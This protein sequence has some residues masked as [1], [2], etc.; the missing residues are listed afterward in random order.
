MTT[1]AIRALAALAGIS[2]LAGNCGALDGNHSPRINTV[3]GNLLTNGGFEESAEGQGTAARGWES[4][5]G[6]RFVVRNAEAIDA[7]VPARD[8]AAAEGCLVSEEAPHSGKRCALIQRTGAESDYFA[9]RQKDIP[10]EP[11]A[12][13]RLRFWVKADA[14]ARELLGV[15]FSASGPEGPAWPIKPVLMGEEMKW[16]RVEVLFRAQVGFNPLAKTDLEFR[17]EQWRPGRLQDKTPERCWLDDVSLERVDGTERAAAPVIRWLVVPNRPGLRFAD[18]E[19]ALGD[20]VEAEDASVEFCRDGV[21][22]RRVAFH[23]QLQSDQEFAFSGRTRRV[24]VCESAARGRCELR[25]R[26]RINPEGG[27]YL[28]LTEPGA[29]RALRAGAAGVERIALA[30]REPGAVRRSNWPVTQGLPFPRGSLAEVSE[31]RVLDPAGREIP[32]QARATSFWEDDSIR[33]ALLD[34]NVEVQP[35]QPTT[36]QVEYGPGARRAQVER[37]IR[38][39]EDGDLIRVDTGPLQFTVSKTHFRAFENVVADGRRALSGS[40]TIQVT[41]DTG[42]T[43]TTSGEKPYVVAVEEAGPLRVVIAVMGWNTD[44]KGERFLTYTTRIH[45]YRGQRFVRVFHTLTNRHKE[46]VMGRHKVADQ[47]WPVADPR[48]PYRDILLPQRNVA[49]CRII[50]PLAGARRWEMA[51][52]DAPPL[53]GDLQSGPVM[54]RQSHRVKGS[55]VLATPNGRV[56]T[57]PLPGS[58]TVGTQ[59]VSVTAAVYRYADLFPKEMRASDQGVEVGLLP[60]SQAEPHGILKGTAR[61]TETLFAFEPANSP[62]GAQ[63]ARAFAEPVVLVNPAWYC[64]SAGFLDDPLVPENDKTIGTYDL[65]VSN[66]VGDLKAPLGPGYD[67]CG[68]MNYGDF[69]YGAYNRWVNLEYDSDLGLFI[70]FARAGDR[71]AYLFGQDSSRHFMDS[72]TGWYTGDFLTHGAN[73]PHDFAHYDPHAPSGHTYTVGLMH[74]YLLTGDRRGLEATRYNAEACFRAF[75]F[76]V[77]AWGSLYDAKD[78]VA[79]PRRQFVNDRH[80]SDP[81]RYPLH[82]YQVTG[83]PRFLETALSVANELAKMPKGW[84]GH[85]DSY[86]HYRWPLVLHYLVQVTGRQDLKQ[87]LID[88]GDWHCDDAYARY[89]EYRAAQCE[90]GAVS[91][92]NNTRMMFQTAYAYE[93]TGR[94]KYL[95][96]LLNMYDGEIESYRNKIPTGLGGKGFGKF[97]DNPARALAYIVPNRMVLVAPAPARFSVRPPGKDLWRI[98]LRNTSETPLEGTLDIGPLPPGV[99]METKLAFALDLKEE[100]QFEFPVEFTDAIAEGRT[101]VPYSVYTRSGRKTGERHGFFAVHALRPLTEKLPEL[102]LH[103]RLDGA[104]PADSALGSGQAV[105]EHPVFIPGKHGQAMGP[106]TRAIAFEQANNVRAEQGTLAVWVRVPARFGSYEL[107]EL[108]GYGNWFIGLRSRNITLSGARFPLSFDHPTVDRW[109]HLAVTWDLEEYRVYLDGRPMVLAGKKGSSSLAYRRQMLELPTPGK[110]QLLSAPGFGL[111]D[112]RIYSLP[113]SPERVKELCADL[114]PGQPGPDSMPGQ[115]GQDQEGE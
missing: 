39:R 12:L 85:D 1:P 80:R 49:D 2:L 93:L 50:L 86:L 111:G 60:F 57:A 30:I 92:G 110:L 34:F 36:C 109:H 88:C 103:A 38:V 45:A 13:Y 42:K 26:P 11:G 70:H 113:L 84:F 46:N 75:Y 104:G 71:F 21:T 115:R 72:D 59:D 10:L 77:K 8:T 28:N 33:W 83:E 82:T 61:T 79:V 69:L 5:G 78:P 15:C 41:E 65:I 87:L 99:N 66:F 31:I 52:N 22:M 7:R 89:G 25:F 35:G 27:G 76:S 18:M 37:P 101:T 114:K 107:L 81:S 97:G 58:V 29:S 24:Y 17:L 3:P 9:W 32:A 74:Y 6:P 91:T 62:E 68:L 53:S 23:D 44:E 102:L 16:Q 19:L 4:A 40:P 64:A 94:R 95:D 43:F 73:F 55:G 105:V 112:L 14:S 48:I 106:A 108:W 63:L 98:A 51:V 96:W 20:G 47:G 100:K 90:A 67:D 54:H 56:T